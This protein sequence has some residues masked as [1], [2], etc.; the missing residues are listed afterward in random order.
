MVKWSNICHELPHHDRGKTDKNESRSSYSMGRDNLLRGTQWAHGCCSSYPWDN[1]PPQHLRRSGSRSRVKTEAPAP[2]VPCPTC[3]WLLPQ[4][5]PPD[6][7]W[8]PDL[9]TIPEHVSSTLARP[10][11]GPASTQSTVKSATV[12]LFSCSQNTSSR[13]HSHSEHQR[14]PAS[15]Q[16]LERWLCPRCWT[17]WP[18]WVISLSTEMSSPSLVGSRSPEWVMSVRTN[19]FPGQMQYW[20]R[21]LCKKVPCWAMC[22]ASLLHC[23]Q[24]HEGD[25]EEVTRALYSAALLIARLVTVF[26]VHF[27]SLPVT[28][29]HDQ[30]APLCRLCSQD[31]YIV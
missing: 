9:L 31:V 17:V 12:L 16:G 30:P 27:P 11:P 22:P 23:E 5:T 21:L 24:G 7:W 29:R 10:S 1:P 4:E 13:R 8:S 15:I 14:Y 20:R 18:G 3:G 6:S 2:P 28:S 19:D 26:L 25:D